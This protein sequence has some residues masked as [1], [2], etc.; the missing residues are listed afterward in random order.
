MKIGMRELSF[1]L[2]LLGINVLQW[3]ARRRTV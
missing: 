1:F 3:L 2:L